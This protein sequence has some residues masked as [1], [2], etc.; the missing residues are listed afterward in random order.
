MNRFRHHGTRFYIGYLLVAMATCPIP[1]PT[2]PA[3][4]YSYVNS[5]ASIVGVV[6][7]HLH[8][9][10]NLCETCIAELPLNP[11]ER[12][13]SPRV[14]SS[15]RVG[16]LLFDSPIVTAVGLTSLAVM[17][18]GAMLTTGLL[19]VVLQEGVLVLLLLSTVQEY[20]HSKYGPWCPW[21]DDDEGD[22]EHRDQP[23]PASPQL[24]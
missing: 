24:A 6:L 3:L 4:V 16:H 17:M 20:S 21:C 18:I 15:L 11:Q 14:R 10:G 12:A 23:A 22:D 9:R 7:I 8:R 19:R 1:L 13:E 5:L 2:V